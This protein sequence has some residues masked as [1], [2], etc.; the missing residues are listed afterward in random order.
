[1]SE[2]SQK[3]CSRKS[4]KYFGVFAVG[5]WVLWV[6]SFGN[7]LGGQNSGEP[8]SEHVIEIGDRICE[9]YQSAIPVKHTGFG[10]AFVFTPN[11]PVIWIT[12]PD[13][14]NTYFM[15]SYR[16]TNKPKC[17]ELEEVGRDP[18]GVPEYGRLSDKWN[19][20]NSSAFKLHEADFR[21]NKWK[22]VQREFCAVEVA[23][24][25]NIL[26]TTKLP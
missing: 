18:L 10:P 1:M 19:E 4:L 12:M 22:T 21:L 25:R 16:R 26:C 11:R 15:A 5:L 9:E 20:A 8:L 24:K 6:L 17:V 14:R 7:L 2:Q 3:G 23:Y 13:G